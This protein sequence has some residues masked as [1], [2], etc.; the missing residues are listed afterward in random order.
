MFQPTAANVRLPRRPHPLDDVAVKLERGYKHIIELNDELLRFKRFHPDVFGTHLDTSTGKFT[1]GA[2]QFDA[3]LDTGR[4]S[5]IAGEALHQLRT[6]LDH[7]IAQLLLAIP[8]NAANIDGILEQSCFPIYVGNFKSFDW[9]K[10]PNISPAA[11][12][13]IS[14]LQ[15][16]NRTDGLPVEDHPLAV[17]ASLNNVDKHRSLIRIVRPARITRIDIGRDFKGTINHIA[18]AVLGSSQTYAMLVEGFV[19]PDTPVD[20]QFYGTTEIA[21]K[22]VGTRDIEPI[23]PTVQLLLDFVG[24]IVNDFASKCF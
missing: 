16:C 7:L 15:P 1:H 21:F 6:T 13:A 20:V 22:K 2:S 19:P 3:G 11:R 10:I 5:V 12:Q 18:P 17:L 9:R 23:I 4:L 8:A 24:G 14:D